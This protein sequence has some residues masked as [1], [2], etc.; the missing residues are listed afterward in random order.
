M[1]E[2]KHQMLKTAKEAAQI[3]G[4]LLLQGFGQLNRNQI[5]LKGMGDYV[6]DLDHLSEEA[7]MAD[8]SSG[9]DGELCSQ[10]PCVCC[11]H[12]VDNGR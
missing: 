6:T 3:G 4:E 8:R 1:T 5:D 12:C 10:Y 9:W 2:D 11:F 7:I